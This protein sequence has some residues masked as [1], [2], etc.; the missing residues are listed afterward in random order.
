VIQSR[1][2]KPKFNQKEKQANKKPAEFNYL[3]VSQRL[4]LPVINLPFLPCKK[5]QK[6]KYGTLVC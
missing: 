5:N 4:V 2:K 6:I 1:L 3:F